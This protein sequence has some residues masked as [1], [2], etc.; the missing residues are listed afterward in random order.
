MYIYDGAPPVTYTIS[1]VITDASG[2]PC[3]RTIRV[4]ARSTGALLQTTQSD[5]TTG[6]YSVT[7][8]TDDEVQRIVLDDDA[9]DF[10]NDLIDRVIPG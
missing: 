7:L 5:I 1:G 9:G 8:A 3:Q 4:Y 10:Y 2:L 6:A